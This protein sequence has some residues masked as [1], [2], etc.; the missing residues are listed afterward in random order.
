MN[1]YWTSEYPNNLNTGIDGWKSN[2]RSKPQQK[3]NGLY[4]MA[5]DHSISG[6]KIVLIG[7][8]CGKNR[9]FLFSYCNHLSSIA[10][11]DMIKK[12]AI[13]LGPI[14]DPALQIISVSVTILLYDVY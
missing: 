6:L 9:T 4:K 10:K 3:L 14:F 13:M 2:G 7:S 8:S 1:T 5:A 12:R 11:P